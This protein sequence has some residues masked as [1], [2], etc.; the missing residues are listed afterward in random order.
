[1]HGA[2]RMMQRII[3]IVVS[4]QSEWPRVAAEAGIGGALA[5]AGVLALLPALAAG[6]WRAYAASALGV[7]ALAGGLWLAAR[8]YARGAG[9]GG[10]LKLAAYG[11]TPLW[12]AYALAPLPGLSLA[13]MIGAVS[14]LYL[15]DRGASPVLN[16]R[17]DESA[18]FTVV[19]MVLAGLGLW[20]AGA[21]AAA[22][23]LL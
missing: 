16:V 17:Q 9:W 14:T 10:A 19:A 11:A 5:H 20:A 6:S 13:P 22:A 2:R 21:A 3:R 15:L 7:P 23:G 18:E 1:M 8:S 12:L 4:P